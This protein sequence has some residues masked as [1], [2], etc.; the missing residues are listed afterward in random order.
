MSR[1]T[2][3]HILL[4]AAFIGAISFAQSKHTSSVYEALELQRRQFSAGDVLG[5]MGKPKAIFNKLDNAYNFCKKQIRTNFGKC[6][7]KASRVSGLDKVA[8][9]GGV[10]KNPGYLKLQQQILVC[11][12]NRDVESKRCESRFRKNA[13]WNETNSLFY[14]NISKTLIC[15]NWKFLKLT[16]F[17]YEY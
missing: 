16:Q 10:L 5:D 17:I 13:A 4:I 3:R 15:W 12:Y 9:K 8:E 1:I 2:A 14:L 7:T 11:E 6:R